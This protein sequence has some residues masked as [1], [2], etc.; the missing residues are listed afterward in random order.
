MNQ[1]KDE[2]D[3]QV[4]FLLHHGVRGL[5]QDH[6]V[7]LYGLSEGNLQIYGGKKISYMLAK[8]L[9]KKYNVSHKKE[10]LQRY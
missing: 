1:T 10:W 6:R 5:S 3:F 7:K 8:V 4:M 2:G 9:M